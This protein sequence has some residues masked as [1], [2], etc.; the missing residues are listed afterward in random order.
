MT[1]AGKYSYP[2]VPKDVHKKHQRCRCDV[3]YLPSN[4]KVQNVHTKV[5]KTAAE[6]QK[7]E[8][9]KRIGLPKEDPEEIK[10]IKTFMEKQTKELTD[11]DQANLR[12]YTGFT[13]TRI[14]H[15]INTGRINPQIQALI[16]GLDVALK[17]GVMPNE[18]I[19]HRDT[20]LGFLGL[21]L[22]NKPTIE[23]LKRIEGYII[24]NDIFTS[25]SFERLELKGRDTEIY[26]KIPA[27]YKGCQYIKPV[28]VP[29][30]KSQEEV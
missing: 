19:L 5:I 21:N 23:E 3:N 30:Y 14:N 16:D 25:M 8:N 20:S 15:G 1:L 4:G 22:P 6:L 18:V 10:E 26:Y 17:D 13:G 2:D 7:I 24:R 28:A 9:R 27:G 29:K 11:E 12:E